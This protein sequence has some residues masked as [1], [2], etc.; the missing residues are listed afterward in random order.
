MNMDFD[1]GNGN[2][3]R[4]E[5]A[6]NPIIKL[7]IREGHLTVEQAQYALRVTSKLHMSKP[8]CEV[9]RELGYVSD[10]TIR[11]TV[12]RNQGE[13]RIGDLLNGLGFLTDEELNR[14]LDLQLQGGRQQ[15]LGD[16]L[17][18]H[19]F[20]ADEKLTEILA[21]QLGLPI[22]ELA[23][24]DP[25]PGL[26][27]RGPV[28]YYE[29]YRFVPY[30]MQPDGSVRIAFADPLDPRSL[31]AAR[32][33][34]GKNVVVCITRVSQLD[35]VLTKR[36][37]EAHSSCENWSAKDPDGNE[38]LDLARILALLHHERWDGS[39]YPF[40]LKAEAI[41]LEARIVAVIDTYDALASERPY[42]KAFPE[43][44]CLEIIR[45]SSGSHFDP[46]VVEAFFENTDII[47]S[48][49]IKW[50]D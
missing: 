25:D 26:L 22:L 36:K 23:A 7:L 33:Y 21:M 48:I 15:K 19:K 35:D 10:E 14:A 46:Q 49:R 40:G 41:P 30:D 31:D 17:I 13:L 28:E 18:Q 24:K 20:L 47:R 38:L 44:K 11:Q 42:K 29:Q 43:E 3:G 6:F 45:E 32:D 34:F 16:I 5:E 9:V 1:S 37:E 50:S 12:R 39:G 4:T 8:L 2:A 27:A